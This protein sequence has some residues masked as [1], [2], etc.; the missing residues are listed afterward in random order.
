VYP[1]NGWVKI[2]RKRY[3]K[4]KAYVKTEVKGQRFISCKGVRQGVICSTTCWRKFFEKWIGKREE[5]E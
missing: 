5:G 1:K 4:A 2:T 3:E